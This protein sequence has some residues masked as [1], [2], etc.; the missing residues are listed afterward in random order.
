MQ[1]RRWKVAPADSKTAQSGKEGL[2]QT[3]EVSNAI[4]VCTMYHNYFLSTLNFDKRRRMQL[5]LAQREHRRKK[6]AALSSLRE[7]VSNYN[8]RSNI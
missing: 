4:E 1:S 7:Q 5:R 2:Q 8:S 6:N 3:D